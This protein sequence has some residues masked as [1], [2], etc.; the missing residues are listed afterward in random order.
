MSDLLSQIFSVEPLRASG[1]DIKVIWTHFA[2]VSELYFHS[3]IF[4]ANVFQLISWLM[5]TPSIALWLK[6]LLYQ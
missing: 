1:A 5:I 6:I 3:P 4:V 2:K